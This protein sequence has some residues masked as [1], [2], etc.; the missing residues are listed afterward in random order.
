MHG[1]A[2]GDESKRIIAKL[3]EEC[4]NAQIKLIE[5]SGGN[6]NRYI[7][8]DLL[9]ISSELFYSD[10][11]EYFLKEFKSNKKVYLLMLLYGKKWKSTPLLKTLE[12]INLYLIENDE[13]KFKNGIKISQFKDKVNMKELYSLGV[14]KYKFKD[15]D[16]VDRDEVEDLKQ[17][18]ENKIESI[19][20]V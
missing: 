8:E 20:N 2:F 18:I 5:F 9:T 19:I 11:L 4:K 1:S 15:R 6:D 3:K 14:I 12:K 10:N 7:S 13:T 16:W 17:K